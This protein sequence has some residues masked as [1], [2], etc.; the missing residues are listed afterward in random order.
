LDY[1]NAHPF[2]KVLDKK[3][4]KIE[5]EITK[6]KDY[7]K[8][9]NFTSEKYLLMV[10]GSAY[11]FYKRTLKKAVKQSKTK[12]E[13]ENKLINPLNKKGDF[14]YFLKNFTIVENNEIERFLNTFISELKEFYF[15]NLVQPMY[16]ENVKYKNGKFLFIYEDGKRALSLN[17]NSLDIFHRMS[18]VYIDIEKGNKKKNNIVEEENKIIYIEDGIMVTEYIEKENFFGVITPQYNVLDSFFSNVNERKVGVEESKKWLL[19]SDF[20]IDRLINSCGGHGHDDMLEKHPIKIVDNIKKH[21][22]WGTL[23]FCKHNK[24]G[25]YKCGYH[26]ENPDFKCKKPEGKFFME[27][28]KTLKN[29]IERMINFVNDQYLFKT[30]PESSQMIIKENI[31]FIKRNNIIEKK[32]EREKKLKEQEVEVVEE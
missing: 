13:H 17:I 25:D 18:T 12:I 23:T 6:E 11:P 32:E 21:N 9:D 27:T 22:N 10:L 19:N 2:Y 26:K 30:L 31:S 1:K 8:I 15:F 7:A 24:C 3:L 5:N 16:V 28:E 14:K 20:I 4:K 29:T